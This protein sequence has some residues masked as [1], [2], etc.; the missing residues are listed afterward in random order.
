MFNLLEPLHN[1]MLQISFICLYL[2]PSFQL[3]VGVGQYLPVPSHSIVLEGS[4]RPL[5]VEICFVRLFY[6]TCICVSS[7]DMA[8]PV[9]SSIF[10]HHKFINCIC[11][12]PINN[13][14]IDFLRQNFAFS[15]VN[16]QALFLHAVSW[17][18]SCGL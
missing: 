15:S 11:L 6:T 1:L 8:K 10:G 9:H 14:G 16:F 17:A 3:L 5:C 12:I 2:M 7:R 13:D 4:S 18:T